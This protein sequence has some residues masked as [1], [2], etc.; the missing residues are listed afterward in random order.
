MSVNSTKLPASSAQMR[1]STARRTI[2]PKS[3]SDDEILGLVTSVARPTSVDGADADAQF[4]SDGAKNVTADAGGAEATTGES[5]IPQDATVTAAVNSPEIAQILDSHPE[6]RDAVESA[7]QV[8][9]VFQTPA[10]AQDAKTQLDELDAMFFSGAPTGHAAL[11]ARIHELSPEAFQGLASAMKEHAAKIGVMNP[12]ASAPSALATS[13]APEGNAG[14]VNPPINARE[15]ASAGPSETPAAQK[16]A[17]VRSPSAAQ[18][19]DSSRAAQIAFYH[20]TNAA[21]VRKIVAAIESQVD[22]LLPG[23]ISSGAKTRIIGEIYRDLDA[24]L[25]GNQQLGKQLRDA[26]ASAAGDVTN[27]QDSTRAHQKAIVTL[28]A[29]RARQALPSIA[30]RVINEWTHSV[31]AANRERLARHESAAKRVD[32]AGG[33]ASDGVNRKAI[34]PRDVDYKRLSDS[35]ILNL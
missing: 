11:A 28:M 17:E 12:E 26:F 34:S 19:P 10:A 31:V 18:T 4:V 8:R 35:D 24:A 7:Q 1:T 2:R 9:A 25:R 29:G 23:S 15:S 16:G 32:I 21:V 27:P 6:L 13:Q 33:G 22:H 14:G 3:P 5:A 20:S 30:K